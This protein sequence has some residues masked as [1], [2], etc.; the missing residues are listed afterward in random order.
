MCIRDSIKTLPV[1]QVT[2]QSLINM[3][4]GREM[5]MEYPKEEVTLGD[6]V[7]EV[8]GLGQKGVFH[9]VSFDLH[10]GEILGISGLVGSGRTEVVKAILGISHATEGKVIYKGTEVVNKNLMK[11]IGVEKTVMLTGDDERIGKSVADELGLDAYY[12]SFP[13]EL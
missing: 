13:L 4:V 8:K 10:K 11:K 9:N 6:T 1:E 5:G 7:L 2:R 12:A 3:M